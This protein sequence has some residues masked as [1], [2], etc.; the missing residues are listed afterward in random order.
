MTKLPLLACAFIMST[1]LSP[2]GAIDVNIPGADSKISK[3]A[4]INYQATNP[5]I[6][7]D[8]ANYVEAL[9][10]MD[11]TKGISKSEMEYAKAISIY[12]A[13]HY[14]NTV[15][16][17][18]DQYNQIRLSFPVAG[19]KS[20]YH[21][22]RYKNPSRTIEDYRVLT[23][24]GSLNLEIDYADFKDYDWRNT[25][26]AYEKLTDK[27]VRNFLQAN[28]K[29]KSSKQISD[30]KGTVFSYPTVTYS[31]WDSMKMPHLKNAKKTTLTI[32]TINFKFKGYNMR[33]PLYHAG[34]V[35]YDNNPVLN[36]VP[37]DKLLAN[38]VLPS[39][40]NL[41]EL[42]QY[43][44]IESL[45]G[46]QYRVP[47]DAIYE[48]ES[49]GTDHQDIRYYK[50]GDI[51]FFISTDNVPKN[52]YAHEIVINGHYNFKTDLNTFWDI[53][54]YHPSASDYINYSIVWNNNIPGLSIHSYEPNKN[55]HILN[56]N[57]YD[58]IYSFTYTIF[59]PSFLSAEEVQKLRNMIEFFDSTNNPNFKMQE[60]VLFPEA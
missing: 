27:D 23:D 35:Y 5:A 53:Y 54:R 37:T 16:S 36:K 60:H 59:Y 14:H 6:E 50:K 1:I 8:V 30:I 56:F 29:R 55:D 31:T 15:I 20:D 25:K 38:Y 45:N 43:S 13:Q 4:Y 3:D 42:N 41:N 47:K 9:K 48:G 18:H 17:V 39:V 58:G 26:I 33:Y 44:R 2:V 12:R 34:F 10:A 49:K 52:P 51:T 40:Q 57:S 11:K 21:I 7:Q 28:A 32:D 22:G 46:V 19:I 24:N